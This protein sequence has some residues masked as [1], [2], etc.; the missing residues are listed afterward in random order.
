MT[1]T[2]PEATLSAIDTADDLKVSPLR[3]DGVA[4]GT[5]TWIWCVV[6]DGDLYVRAYYGTGSRWYA[7]AAARPDGRI[8]AAGDMYDVTFEPAAADL[9]DRIDQAYGT[10]YG[11]S[12][13]LGT[14]VSDRARAACF[15]VRPR[16]PN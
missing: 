3:E 1:G 8:H 16:T 13:Y 4:Y 11:D 5:P 9:T 7:A 14:M 10:K 12:P 6:V 15:R 2:W